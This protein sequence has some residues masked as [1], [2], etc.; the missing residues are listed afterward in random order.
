LF[1]LCCAPSNDCGRVSDGFNLFSNTSRKSWAVTEIA[2]GAG[3]QRRCPPKTPARLC[4]HQAR[5]VLLFNVVTTIPAAMRSWIFC[6][7]NFREIFISNGAQH[8][9]VE[10]QKRHKVWLCWTSAEIQTRL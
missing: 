5:A 2:V 4:F 9:Q 1:I 7:F 8:P 6:A 10:W 3:L